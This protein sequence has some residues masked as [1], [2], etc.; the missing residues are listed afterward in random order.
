MEQSEL[1]KFVY[2]DNK[3]TKILRG[4]VLEE[5]DYLYKIE[6]ERTGQIITLGKRAIIKVSEVF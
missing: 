3:Q 4:R 1:K 2:E 6:A 5:T